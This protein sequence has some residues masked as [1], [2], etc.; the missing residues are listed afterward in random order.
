[1]TTRRDNYFIDTSAVTE[2]AGGEDSMVISRAASPDPLLTG[3]PSTQT[4]STS[5][6]SAQA[7]FV[8]NMQDFLDTHEAQMRYLGAA[9]Q[10]VWQQLQNLQEQVQGSGQILDKKVRQEAIAQKQ[11]LESLFELVA[12]VRQVQE[13][14]RAADHEVLERSHHQTQ[15][16]LQEAERQLRMVREEREQ[17]KGEQRALFA[18]FKRSD[19]E[20]NQRIAE[21]EELLRQH[22][23]VAPSVASAPLDPNAPR[24]VPVGNG[25]NPQNAGPQTSGNG[26]Q[27]EEAGPVGGNGGKQP[28][29][30]GPVQ[31]NSGRRPVGTAP[32]GGNGGNQPPRNPPRGNFGGDPEPSDDDDDDN[33]EWS[34][35]RKNWRMNR[36]GN[37]N[38]APPEDED[39]VDSLAKIPFEFDNARKHNLRHWLME[40]EIYFEQKPKKFRTD[41]NKVLFAG[42]YTCGLAKE[43]FMEYIETKMLGPAGADYATWARFRQEVRKRFLSTQE[44]ME[45]A[46]KMQQFKYSA[47]IGDYLT[48][49]EIMNQH[50][51]MKGASYRAA[52]LQGLPNEIRE[53]HSR[54][55]PTD[56]DSEY[57]QQLERA[58]KAHEAY[59]EQMK[60]LGKAESRGKELNHGGNSRQK[61]KGFKIKGRAQ[62]E[63]KEKG[64][65]KKST[66]K[67]KSGN[68]PIY[69]DYD[70]ATKGV[71]QPVRDQRKTDG[72]CVR[73]GRKGHLWKWCRSDANSSASISSF[74]RKRTRDD[75][76]DH[77]MEPPEPQPQRKRMRH[78]ARK[79]AATAAAEYTSG[80]AFVRECGSE[81]EMDFDKDF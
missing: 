20:R 47:N 1:M 36:G 46:M 66:S 30:A 41:R 60:M 56:D 70:E 77:D 73:C 44:A 67:N 65:D 54:F 37:R 13:A 39:M 31:G 11:H 17:E 3:G 4:R 79:P 12:N 15:T 62:T 16:Q 80:Q 22:L 19:E 2:E 81:S 32:V 24:T 48:R 29:D 45:N 64:Q 58:G 69:H 9:G 34:H 59:Q 5:K 23:S 6:R 25:K 7:Q 51:Q 14:A 21:M 40:C 35:G 71:P 78:R 42:T 72:V 52:L 38:S 10:A 27:P 28:E 57:I 26:K 75:D 33:S 49:M 74:S 63:E 50:A 53:R 18:Q 55:D 8:R 68:K 61:E 76:G 43:W